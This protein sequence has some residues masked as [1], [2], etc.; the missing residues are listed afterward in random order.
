MQKI[1]KLEN[2]FN[3]GKSDNLFYSIIYMYNGNLLSFIMGCI[4]V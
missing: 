2:G 3:S 4:T 1:R